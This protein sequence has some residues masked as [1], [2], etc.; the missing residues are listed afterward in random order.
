MGA[1]ML[2]HFLTEQHKVDPVLNQ[3][4]TI[5]TKLIQKLAAH[6]EMPSKS[7]WHR[8]DHVAQCFLLHGSV[9]QFPLALDVHVLVEHYF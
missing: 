3:R 9:H 6:A 8:A 4:V 7:W 2:C 1:V 5:V